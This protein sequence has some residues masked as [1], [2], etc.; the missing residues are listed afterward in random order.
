MWITDCIV[1]LEGNK[2]E[3]MSGSNMADGVVREQGKLHHR[4]VREGILKEQLK[5]S[6]MSRTGIKAFQVNG[7]FFRQERLWQLEKYKVVL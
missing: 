4:E 2:E 6:I 7:K 1:C 3:D 5:F